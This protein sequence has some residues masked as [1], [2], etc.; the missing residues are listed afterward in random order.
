MLAHVTISRDRTTEAYD[1]APPTDPVLLVRSVLERPDAELDYAC[2]KIVF[3]QFID[4][5]VNRPGVLAELN[6]LSDAVREMAGPNAGPDAKLG[7]LRRY[8]YDSGAWNDGKPFAYDQSDPLGQR[9]ANKL[10]HNYLAN[11]LGQCVSMPILFLILAERLG[12]DVALAAAPSHFFVRYSSQSG[13]II[14]IETTSGGHPAREL[15]FRQGFP[16]SNRSIET[17]IYMRGLTKRQAITA[18]ASTIIE[19]LNA[20]ERFEKVIAVTDVI[21]AHDKMNVAAMLCKG[22]A[23]GM[24]LDK[25]RAAF[26]RYWEWTPTQRARAQDWMEGNEAWFALAEHLGWL[27]FEE[28]ASDSDAPSTT[29]DQQRG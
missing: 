17:G 20:E 24:L 1:A 19:R 21:L 3:D 16:I 18:M 7:T 22:T 14:N 11:R 27:P 29:T 2:A 9:L 15:W 13:Q 4:P 6:R 25:F 23:C 10:L 28:A 12:L 26:P 5:S 8:L